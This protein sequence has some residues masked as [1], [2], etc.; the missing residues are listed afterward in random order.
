MKDPDYDHFGG[1]LQTLTDCLVSLFTGDV[2]NVVATC[3]DV[4]DVY[5]NGIPITLPS[6]ETVTYPLTSTFQINPGNRNTCS[7]VLAIRCRDTGI[8]AGILA[9]ADNGLITDSSWR[10]S[11]KYEQGWALPGFT[12]NPEH[13]KQAST[14][15]RNGAHPWQFLK[16][17]SPYANWIWTDRNDGTTN[18][19]VHCR[20]YI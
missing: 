6:A 3:D 2:V 10:C 7:N 14:Y 9:S 12:E 15:G 20:K 18:M 13:W 8:I 5:V 19:H 4:M 16:S 11:D 17:I 1:G